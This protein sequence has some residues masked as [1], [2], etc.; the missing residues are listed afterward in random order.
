MFC[1]LWRHG[2][3][4]FFF[5]REGLQFTSDFQQ[6]LDSK[7]VENL[8]HG[9]RS[10]SVITDSIHTQLILCPGVDPGPGTW[11]EMWHRLQTQP[12]ANFRQFPLFSL[13]LSEN[14]MQ[15]VEGIE[16]EAC[17]L[18]KGWVFLCTPHQVH[19][20]HALSTFQEANW[21]RNSFQNFQNCLGLIH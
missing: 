8:P 19:N 9:E 4:S 11:G 17:L 2:F 13:R 20:Q 18:Y 15:V 1:V 5:L 21:W 14:S 12:G 10:L 7:Q 6:D 3:F 16:T